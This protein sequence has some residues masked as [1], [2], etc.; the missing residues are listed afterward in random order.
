M[1]HHLKFIDKMC[2][3]EIDQ[4]SIIENTEYAKFCPHT[5]GQ[6]AGWEDGWMDS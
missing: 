3:F 1:P 6:T 4:A 2:K 5:A